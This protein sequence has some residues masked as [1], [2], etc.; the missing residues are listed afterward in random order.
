MRTILGWILGFY[1]FVTRSTCRWS[2]TNDPR[3]R[4]RQQGV[5]YIYAALHAHHG[6][7][8]ISADRGSCAI[9]SRSAD[10]DVAIPSLRICGITPIRGSGGDARKGG[11]TALRS[12]INYIDAEHPAC[13]AVDG[14]KGPRGRVHSGIAKMSQKSGG[15]VVPLILLAS[16]RWIFKKSWDRLQVVLPFSTVH[17]YFADPMQMEPGESSSEFS[18]RVEVVLRDLEIK[19][20][21]EE[22]LQAGTVATAAKDEPAVTSTLE[23]RAA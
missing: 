2:V 20:D 13:I 19:H 10:G 7:A 8:L 14:P 12:A 22:A 1:T 6:A 9:V 5:P 15:V 4:L 21:Y 23:R 18:K 17:V 16:K 3:G 11:V